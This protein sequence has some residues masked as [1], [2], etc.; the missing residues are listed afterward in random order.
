MIQRIETA[1]ADVWRGPGKAPLL[2][3]CLI[4]HETA[5]H[6]VH[7][8]QAG[9][10]LVKRQAPRQLM[11]G[12]HDFQ[13]QQPQKA[14]MMLHIPQSA[15]TGTFDCAA[16]GLFGAGHRAGI[17]DARSREQKSLQQVC[18]GIQGNA[19]LGFGFHTL[20]QD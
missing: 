18:F 13:P 9:A 15:C 17:N 11:A 12:V 6:P 2:H 20:Q 19:G 5:F 10:G 14:L 3:T 7:L 1:A 16:Q 4:E 8:Q